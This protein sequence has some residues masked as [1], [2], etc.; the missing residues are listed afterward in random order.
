MSTEAADTVATERSD[1][2]II[3]LARS[4]PELF[5]EIFDRHYRDIRRY[6][7]RRVGVEAADDLASETFVQA[8]AGLHRYD[9]ST[10]NARPWLFGIATNL[11]RQ[12]TKSETR[13]YLTL[14]RSGRD[15]VHDHA[16]E[17]A[18]RVSAQACGPALG[19]AL[20]ALKPRDRDVLL[21]CAYADFSYEQIA[22]ALNIPVGTVRSRLNRARTQ[23]RLHLPDHDAPHQ[24][25]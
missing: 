21:L 13:G 17:V 5:V 15:P 3:R 20:A 11:L 25:S 14:A 22:D 6:L 7:A 4:H 9:T 10:G 19:A 16:D 8:L 2:E 23:V 1:A 12:H 18:G 24:E